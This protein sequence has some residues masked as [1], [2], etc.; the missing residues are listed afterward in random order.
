MGITN[1]YDL[2]FKDLVEKMLVHDPNS[3]PT[4][5]DIMN[6]PWMIGPIASKNEIENFFL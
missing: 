3:R 2:D 4:L 6:H 1:E 5:R